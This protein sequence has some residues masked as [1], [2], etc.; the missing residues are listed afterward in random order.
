[1]DVCVC[2]LCLC[3]CLFSASISLQLN[4]FV[5]LYPRLSLP[6]D[7]C[8]YLYAHY[9]PVLT[10]E[11]TCIRIFSPVLNLVNIHALQP[12]LTLVCLC[13]HA[14]TGPVVPDPQ[15]LPPARPAQGPRASARPWRQ[16]QSVRACVRAGVHLYAFCVCWGRG[17]G[18]SRCMHHTLLEHSQSAHPSTRCPYS[19]THTYTPAHTTRTQ[20]HAPQVVQGPGEVYWPGG[21]RARAVAQALQ[22][23][24]LRAC[25]GCAV[26]GG[27]VFDGLWI[28]GYVIVCEDKHPCVVT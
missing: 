14:S 7:A 27:W 21:G 16:T 23:R 13:V 12:V 19:H 4:R 20:R 1:V 3:T 25:G 26:K 9:S 28:S 8:V 24:R 22:R 18:S 15:H 2:I 5:A 6:A 10:P 11:C 17:L